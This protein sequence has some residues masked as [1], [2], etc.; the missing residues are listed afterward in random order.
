MNDEV[1][2]E[3]T[4]SPFHYLFG[5]VDAVY[6]KLPDLMSDA[7]AANAFVKSLDSNLRI[8]RDAAAKHQPA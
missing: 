2:A 5:T 1:S 6:V 4:E 7:A 8:L 3:T